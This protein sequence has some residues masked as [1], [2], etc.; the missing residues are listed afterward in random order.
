M[1]AKIIKG[2]DGMNEKYN[3]KSIITGL[4]I[5]LAG[6]LLVLFDIFVGKTDI[7]LWVSIGCSLLASGIVILVTA[8]LVERKK[9]DYLEDWG[10]EKIYET[11]A[12]KNK[13]SDPKLDKAKKQID[14]VAFGLKSFREMHSKKVEKLLKKCIN[15]RILTMNPEQTNIF[16]NQREKEENE[17]EG[18]IRN[19]INKLVSWANQLNSRDYKGRIEIKGYKCMTLDF[20]WRVDDDVYIGPYWYGVGSQQTITYK[21]NKGKKGFE[22]YTEYFD[23]LWDDE[24]NNDILTK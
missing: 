18:Q 22:I 20:Y 24:E 7:N 3:S 8:L 23:K 14:V 17:T 19:S 4:L 12:E 15:F 16:L 11:R 9:V 13:D 10:L 1:R 6:I 2:G 21:F 5:I